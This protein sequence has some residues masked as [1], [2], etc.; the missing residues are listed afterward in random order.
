MNV[1]ECG[2]GIEVDE[3]FLN[4]NELKQNIKAKI[5]KR[6]YILNKKRT[7]EQRSLF[8][9]FV[10]FLSGFSFANINESQDCRR[11]GRAFL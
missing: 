10:F 8:V 3:M 1:S 4:I 6:A 7:K 5:N 2:K 9:F 11:K